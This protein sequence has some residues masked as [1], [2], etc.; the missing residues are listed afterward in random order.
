MKKMM[1]LA[2][3]SLIF[4]MATQAQNRISGKVTD[5]KNAA[6]PF[7]NVSLMSQDSALI[8]GSTT[9][10]N[11]KFKLHITTQKLRAICFASRM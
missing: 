5:V 2:C 8:T 7:V 1:F 3:L 6:I 11:G 10:D 4:T 9:D